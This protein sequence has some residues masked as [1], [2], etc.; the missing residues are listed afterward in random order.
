MKIAIAQLNPKTGALEANAEAMLGAAHRAWKAG[1]DRCVLPLSALPGVHPRDLL[2]HK[3]FKD[4]YDGVDAEICSSVPPKRLLVYGG[5]FEY[6]DGEAVVMTF[7][8]KPGQDPSRFQISDHRMVRYGFQA[9]SGNVDIYCGPMPEDIPATTTGVIEFHALAYVPGARRAHEERICALAKR[10][11]IWVASVNLVGGNDTKIYEG[12]S[13][14]VDAQGNVRARLASWKEDFLVIDLDNPPPPVPP[15]EAR[16]IED[17]RD[18]LVLGLR[19][20]FHKSGFE[21]AVLGL[22]GGI[23]SAL[24]AYLAVQAL[25]PDHVIG[26]AMPSRY[27]SDHSVEDAQALAQ[28]LGLRFHMLPI[29]GMH[30]ASV[31]ALRP[32]LG[33]A[34]AGLTD[35]NLQ[36]RLRG[37][38][39]MAV[40]N[41]H[42]GLVLSTGNKSEAAVGYATLYGDTNGALCVIAD[43][44]KH[45]VYAMARL[46]N[47]DG[48]KIPVRSIDKPPSAELSPGQKDSDSLPDYDRLDAMLKLL[49]EQRL[50][51]E[52]LA[53]ATGASLE[54]AQR[55]VRMVH[56]N[57]FKRR[58]A[59]PTLEVSSHP[60]SARAYPILHGFT[61]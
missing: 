57:E 34:P 20:Y 21:T 29:E 12:A 36:A 44:Y 31:E 51:P 35:Q 52:Q 2:K 7:P 18:A 58:Q 54:E 61:G 19:D 14:F 13:L 15:R 8:G 47:A 37:V 41:H 60:L 59:P 26:V 24:T 25:G 33:G 3:S 30:A 38:S 49:I 32:V 4:A 50:P 45:E 40:A 10:H 9:E 55:V 56:I 43:L 53:Q 48:P 11:N 1:A 46:A 17:K 23:D 6:G 42:R 16:E 39:L 27:S 22:S 5:L 28:L